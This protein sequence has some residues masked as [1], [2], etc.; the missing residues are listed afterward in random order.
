MRSLNGEEG[1]SWLVILP[2]PGL[3]KNFKSAKVRPY[4]LTNKEQVRNVWLPCLND[5]PQTRMIIKG[6]AQ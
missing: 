3:I 5:V 1:L 6:S 4:D 2:H